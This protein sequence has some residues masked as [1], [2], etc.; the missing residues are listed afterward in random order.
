MNRTDNELQPRTK[1]DPRSLGLT[2]KPRPKTKKPVGLKIS[3][4][5]VKLLTQLSERNAGTPMQE[6][7][8]PLVDRLIFREALS[9]RNQDAVLESILSEAGL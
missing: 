8:G 9:L 3:F 2:R 7:K 5:G 6:D 4:L 1:K